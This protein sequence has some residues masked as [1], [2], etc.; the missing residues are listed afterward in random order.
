MISDKQRAELNKLL[1]AVQLAQEEI[2][3]LPLS[4]PAPLRDHIFDHI[5]GCLL[6]TQMTAITARRAGT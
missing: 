6:I 5:I 2:D 4:V 3:T 1:E